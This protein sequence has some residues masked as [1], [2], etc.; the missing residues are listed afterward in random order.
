M[1]DLRIEDFSI[2]GLEYVFVPPG[3]PLV[4]KAPDARATTSILIRG[5]AGTGKTTL[6]VAL[7]HAISREH[8][9][10]TLY[11]T[12]E[13]VATELAYKA[14]TLGLPAALVDSWSSDRGHE[15]GAILAEHLLGTDAGTQRLPTLA[16]RKRAAIE[17]VSELLGVESDADVVGTPDVRVVVIDAFGLPE[18]EHQED[19]QLRNELLELIQSLESVGVTTIIVEEAGDATEA[20]LP[21][22]VDV[23]FEIELSPDP[24]TGDLVRRLMCRKSRYGTSLAGPHDYGLEPDGAPAVWPDVMFSSSP[25][26]PK[27]SPPLAPA[28]FLPFGQYCL[29]CPAGSVLISEYDEPFETTPVFGATPGLVMARL[30]CGPMIESELSAGELASYSE[31]QGLFAASWKL[32]R[33]ASTGRINAVI[34]GGLDYF[35]S[36]PRARLRALRAIAMLSEAG[37]TVC[38]HGR[39]AELEAAHAIA[40]VIQ[41]REQ[42]GGTL[43]PEPAPRPCRADRW[44]PTLVERT[45]PD[46]TDALDQEV[47]AWMLGI[48]DPDEFRSI[49]DK[50]DSIRLS[51]VDAVSRRAWTYDLLG[52][53]S[54]GRHQLFPRKHGDHLLAAQISHLNATGDML[55]AAKLCLE[56][57]DHPDV[58]FDEWWSEFSAIFA[59]NPTA[60]EQLENA[61]ATAEPRQMIA[62][63]RALARAAE[64]D[65]LAPIIDACGERFGLP[66]WYLDRL[67][68][69]LCLDANR[70]PLTERAIEELTELSAADGVPRIHRAEMLYNVGVAKFR[71]GDHEGAGDAARRAL[72]LN[73]MLELPPQ[74]RP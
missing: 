39:R 19:N 61:T 68:A 10:V 70:T 44:M 46:F 57:S 37:M 69:E 74:I 60:I 1:N 2:H 18:I 17:A 47:R 65:R 22:V 64:L 21:F 67:R 41:T 66:R 35:T 7:A 29:L 34:V 33:A 51:D 54:Y 49:P 63:M 48:D 30:R 20:W 26:L 52:M 62:L 43:V 53:F 55:G 15:P 24:D 32:V 8:G 5:G 56:H 28:I 4:A 25:C 23:V 71:L 45:N 3:L 14:S 40:T 9:G 42:R 58:Q 11:L 59:G 73:P 12:T 27:A 13:F 38:L 16:E 6:A 72:G 36:R 31:S 50:L